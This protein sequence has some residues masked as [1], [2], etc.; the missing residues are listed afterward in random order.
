MPIDEF[1]LHQ[2]VRV[3]LP[4]RYNWATEQGG[5]NT[6]VGDLTVY[7]LS[8]FKRTG[9]R[10]EL[11]RSSRRQRPEDLLTVLGNGRLALP[12]LCSSPLT[13]DYWA[14]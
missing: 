5:P 6:G 2:F 11:G 1:G 8:F 13:G 7:D 12:E 3:I 9:P 14:R 4:D 10:S